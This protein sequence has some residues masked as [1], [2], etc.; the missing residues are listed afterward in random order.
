[1]ASYDAGGLKMTNIS[2]FLKSLKLTWIRKMLSCNSE[3][4]IFIS[5]YLS[6][7]PL[8]YN[9]EDVGTEW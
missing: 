1:M 8:S 3:W 6:V 7:E 4:Q 5:N 2:A 9:F